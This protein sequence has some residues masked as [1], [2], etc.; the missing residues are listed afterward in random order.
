MYMK[1]TFLTMILS[2][3]VGTMLANPVG[4]SAAL[5]KARA[6]MQDVNPAATIA[7]A[8]SG[9]RAISANGE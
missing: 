8:P 2:M 6:F 5:A 4:K 9:R 1:K 3:V 7:E